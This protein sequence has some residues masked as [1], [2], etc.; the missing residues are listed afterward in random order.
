MSASTTPP[1]ADWPSVTTP[2]QLENVD[3]GL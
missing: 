1:E 2:E 3:T